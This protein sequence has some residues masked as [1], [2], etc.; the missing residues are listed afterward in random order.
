VC[1]A[2][3]VLVPKLCF[4]KYQLE[5]LSFYET[6]TNDIEVK[7]N[8]NLPQHEAEFQNHHKQNESAR[9]KNQL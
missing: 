6:V 1:Y 9:K 5:N 8:S 4:K 2:T 3:P 7:T